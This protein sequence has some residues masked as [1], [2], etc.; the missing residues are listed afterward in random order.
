M[1]KITYINICFYLFIN[2]VIFYL[3]LMVINN[4]FTMLKGIFE[5]KDGTDLFYYLWIILFF[6]IL[7]II[8]FSAPL[9]FFSTIKNK[10][11]MAAS[12]L[13][14]FIIG[15]FI[16]VY[17]TSQKT[18]DLYGFQKVTIGIITYVIF[19]YKSIFIKFKM[20]K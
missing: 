18:F 15:Y 6:P 4:D 3:S 5:I 8:L 19:F 11:F 1:L 16:Y 14:I 9:Y 7:D 12:I 13:C 10:F 20:T 17:F 2:C